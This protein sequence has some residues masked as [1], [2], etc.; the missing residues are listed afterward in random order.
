MTT[1][2]IYTVLD[3]IVNR[4]KSVMEVQTNLYNFGIDL[5][6]ENI[7]I[8]RVHVQQRL[9]K[10]TIKEAVLSFIQGYMVGMFTLLDIQAKKRGSNV[11]DLVGLLAAC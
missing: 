1:Q 7:K 11:N 2:E 9:E 10:R 4:A 3:T 5:G 8:N 6:K